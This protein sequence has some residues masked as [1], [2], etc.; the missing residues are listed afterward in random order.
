MC[1][2]ASVIFV[3]L[4]NTSCVCQ[5]AAP[6]FAQAQSLISDAELALTQAKQFMDLAKTIPDNTREEF[7]V[8]LEKAYKGLQAASQG[9][10]EATQ[11]CNVLSLPT[12]FQ[13]FNAAWAIIRNLLPIVALYASKEKV[14]AKLGISIP[15]APNTIII[16]DPGCFVKY[17][18]IKTQPNPNQ[19]HNP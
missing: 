3:S 17:Y 9:L 6:H 15:V 19:Q 4:S 7:D 18:S 13:D 1:I 16:K 5:K 11:S 12:V 8:Q 10:T 2:S 14:G